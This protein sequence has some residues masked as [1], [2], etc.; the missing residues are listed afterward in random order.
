MVIKVNDFAA[1]QELGSVAKSPRWAIAY[2]FASRQAETIL[3]DISF[4]VGR[5]GTV[6]PV[7]EL[8]PVLLSGSTISRATL[9]NEDFINELDARPGDTVIIEKGGDVIPKVSSVVMAKRSGSSKPFS[10]ISV[11]PECS[12]ALIRPEDEASWFCENPDCPAQVRGR[13]EHFVARN[14]MDIDGLGES[15]IDTLVNNNLIA[16]VSDLY[17]LHEKRDKLLEMD[18]FAEKKVDNLL[19]AIEA[20]KERPFDRV[21]YGVGIRFVGSEVARILTKAFPS[22]EIL[23]DASAVD[24]EAV[25]GIGPRIALSVHQ[26][27]T[28]AKTRTMFEDLIRHGV[29]S[30]ADIQTSEE[31]PFFS[32]KTFVLTGTLS[33][34]SRNEAKA[35]IE[36]YGGSVTGSVSSKT[37]VVLAGENPGSKIDKAEK[38][39]ITI[40][41]EETFQQ[42]LK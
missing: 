1:Q 2:K 32:G 11:C 40:I 8:E 29:Q 10:F 34:G 17:S 14:G 18:R 21:V 19:A 23:R 24:L 26:Y 42:H 31:H 33:Q 36:S 20:S 30:E 9:H 5:T 13:I 25:D 3:N 27:F 41:D 16:S 28:N 4:Q 38:L 6:T 15:I 7:A 39:G 12:T 35:I 22:F 37:D